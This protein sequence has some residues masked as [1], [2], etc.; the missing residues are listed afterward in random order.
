MK[1]TNTPASV[2]VL[3]SYQASLIDT[4]RQAFRDGHMSPLMVLPTGGGKTVCF[5]YLAAR[6]RES[7]KRL[8]ILVHREELVDQ[9]SRTLEAFAVPHGIIAPGH[10]HD[11]LATVHVSSVFSV[12]RRMDRVKVPDYVICDEAH[13]CIKQSTW[14][15]LI[16]TW[17][18]MNPALRLIGVTATPARLSGEG[19]GEMFDHMAIGPS[20]RELMDMGALA[21]YRLFAPAVAADLSGV[22]TVA[23]DFNRGQAAAAMDKPAIIGDAVAHYRRICEGAPAV[24]FCASIQHAEHTRDQFTAAGF[25]AVCLDGKMDK[26]L[27]RSAIR[28]FQAGRIH[29]ITSCDL[30]SEG[31][32]VPGIISAILLRPT[33]SLALYLQQVG[34][35]L[36]PKPEPAIILDHVGNTARH[37]MPDDPREWTL[38]GTQGGRKTKA[39]ED[40]VRQCGSC[41]ATSPAAAP[42]CRECGTPF[43]VRS[44]EIDQVAGEL[45]EIE[46]QRI[47]REAAQAQGSARDLQALAE[48]G[49]VRGMKNP[50]GWARHVMA[51]REAK[52]NRRQ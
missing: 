38:T 9:V 27:R 49:R 34:R 15:K 33:Q 5:S 24:A 16:D 22:R 21:Q 39:A 50:E 7:G 23:G 48:L 11:L 40:A 1:N 52:Q 31:F 10:P 29:V 30:I 51:A 2:P 4:L 26:G 45:S 44:R 37:G 13:H 3:R 6:L 14:G 20:S 35:A 46:V 8:Q 12:T 36:R 42:K 25:A 32:D 28:D 43:P 47:K 17:R 18:G 19:L 41:Y